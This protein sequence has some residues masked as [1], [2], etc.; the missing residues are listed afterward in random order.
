MAYIFP[1]AAYT[2]PGRQATLSP[3]ILVTELYIIPGNIRDCVCGGGGVWV[4]VGG[5]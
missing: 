3:E 1:P 5:W 2:V 4:G